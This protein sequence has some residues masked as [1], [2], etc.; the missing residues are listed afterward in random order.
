MWLWSNCRG[1]SSRFTNHCPLAHCCDENLMEQFPWT[2]YASTFCLCGSRVFVV[3]HLL[4]ALII[5]GLCHFL[6]HLPP[7]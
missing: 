7:T 6:T 3:V 5:G 2:S 4:S 1:G